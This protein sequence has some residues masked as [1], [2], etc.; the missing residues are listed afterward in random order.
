MLC[1]GTCRWSVLPLSA[2]LWHRAAGLEPAGPCWSSQACFAFAE[3]TLL[4]PGLCHP[5]VSFSPSQMSLEPG[6]KNGSSFFTEGLCGLWCQ[7]QPVQPRCDALAEAALPAGSPQPVCAWF[8]HPLSHAV[9]TAAWS[10][11][12]VG[13]YQT[14]WPYQ[15]SPEVTSTLFVQWQCWIVCL[16][17][18]CSSA[19][20]AACGKHVACSVLVSPDMPYAG[21]SD[22]LLY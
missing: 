22:L 14:P 11:G 6:W 8:C 18:T 12:K 3:F 13:G 17:G 7:C 1:S 5:D 21:C 9:L 19:G 16:P 4:T 10:S 2:F 15:R 20:R